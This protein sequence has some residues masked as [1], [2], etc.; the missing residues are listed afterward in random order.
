MFKAHSFRL[1]KEGLEDSASLRK[2]SELFSTEELMVHIEILN[3]ML[4]FL[5]YSEFKNRERDINKAKK[6]S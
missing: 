5:D 4:V 1:W 3:S 2:R 6:N